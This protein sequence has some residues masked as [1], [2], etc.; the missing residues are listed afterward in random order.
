MAISTFAELKTAI[1]NWLERDDLSSRIP[2]F[3]SLAE[4]RI[5][6]DLRIR[7]ME[8][9]S[10]ITVDAQ[11]E[12]LPTRFLGLR[13]SYLDSDGQRV[14]Y[15][16]PDQFWLLAVTRE[17]GKPVAFTIEGE[18]FVFAP[19]PSGSSY[20]FKVHYWQKFASLSADGDTNWLLTNARGLLLYGSLLEA[21][22]YLED[23]VAATKWGTL[24]RDLLDRVNKSNRKDRFPVGAVM[25]SEVAKV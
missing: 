19:Y 12:A 8:T 15:Y 21:S 6:L 16:P 24:Y 23:D 3:V 13:R 25:R 5:A 22:L 7:P 2:E 14:D 11:T 4:D 20:T 1:G 10:S 18:N 9:S 17:N